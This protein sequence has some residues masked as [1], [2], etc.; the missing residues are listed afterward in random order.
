MNVDI[1]AI[2]GIIAEKRNEIPILE[3]QRSTIPVKSI[4][5]VI[6]EDL[7]LIVTI[8]LLI[9]RFGLYERY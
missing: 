5:L 4:K 8:D 9:K 2:H 3:Q 1:R 6:I 7:S